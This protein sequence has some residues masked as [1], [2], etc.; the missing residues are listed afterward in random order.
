MHTDKQFASRLMDEI[1]KNGAMDV[2][3]SDGAAAEIGQKAQDPIREH[4]WLRSS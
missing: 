1:R 2:L 4:P 3:V